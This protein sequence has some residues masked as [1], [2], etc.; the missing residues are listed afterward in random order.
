MMNYIINMV[1]F[2][3]TPIQ[4]VSSF[5]VMCFV[6]RGYI[7]ATQYFES[8]HIE[9]SIGLNDASKQYELIISIVN[10]GSTAF[11]VGKTIQVTAVGP[12]GEY[13][14]IELETAPAEFHFKPGDSRDIR[15]IGRCSAVTHLSG[16]YCYETNVTNSIGKRINKTYILSALQQ[17]IPLW[18]W[19]IGRLLARVS[20]YLMD[21]WADYLIKY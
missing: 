11:I 20:P 13:I 16:F 12:Q 15:Y 1:I 2:Y 21:K 14:D 5:V 10:L 9:I 8:A 3:S 19:K 17:P 7:K 4:A 6:V 18:Q